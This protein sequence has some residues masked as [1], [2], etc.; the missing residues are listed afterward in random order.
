[1]STVSDI[2][3][4]ANQL[5]GRINNAANNVVVN[6][7]PILLQQQASTGYRGRTRF[8]AGPILLQQGYIPP[9]QINPYTDISG[10]APERLW[11]HKYLEQVWNYKH[12]IAFFI[13][14]LVLIIFILFMTDQ[15][16]AGM[17]FVTI[18]ETFFIFTIGC[19]FY[20]Y[21]FRH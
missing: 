17:S 1:M 3:A 12:A 20:F 2:I 5:S 13:V 4:R 10:T 19:L 14:L 7:R 21:V 15:L 11:I 6:S 8:A 9:P 18:I 16:A